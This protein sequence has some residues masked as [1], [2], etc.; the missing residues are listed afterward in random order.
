M[1]VLPQALRRQGFRWRTQLLL[2]PV[3]ET[4]SLFILDLVDQSFEPLTLLRDN[5]W[6]VNAL[7]AQTCFQRLTR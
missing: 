7:L 3:E 6:I 5:L 2:H 1:I 4:V